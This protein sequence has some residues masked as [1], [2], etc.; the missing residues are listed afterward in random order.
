MYVVIISGLPC[1]GKSKFAER[2]AARCRFPLLTKD[3]IKETLFD[4]LGIGDRVW[5]RKL[6]A[7]AYAVMFAHA[8]ELVRCRV[9][10]ILEGNFR[11]HQ[12]RASIRKLAGAG[13]QLVQVLC[14]A[15]PDVLID[16]FRE[17]ARVGVR[18]AGHVD[19][20]SLPEIES[21]I[22]S[23]PQEQ[24]WE[25]AEAIVCDTTHDWQRNI[26]ASVERVLARVT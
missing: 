22:A 21:E 8:N 4:T 23:S 10:C 16:R 18:H 9:D 7:A 24:L 20:E 2:L 14:R 13:V 25:D 5:S 3:A 6:S 19:M 17:R 1:S 15:E 26:D 11:A 12:H